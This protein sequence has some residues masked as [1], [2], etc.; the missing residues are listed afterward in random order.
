MV[1]TAKLLGENIKDKTI[2]LTGAMIPYRFKDSDTLFNLGGAFAAVQTL[3]PGVY[4]AIQGKIFSWDNVK[5]NR[6]IGEFEKL[7]K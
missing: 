2:V 6:E 7:T 4:I 1:E 3:D 5:K